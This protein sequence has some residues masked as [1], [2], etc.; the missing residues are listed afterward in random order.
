MIYKLW[1][2]IKIPR[3]SE[4]GF[5]STTNPMQQLSH[6]YILI[7]MYLLL[8]RVLLSISFSQDRFTIIRLQKLTV[9]GFSY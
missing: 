3:S 8:P 9:C 4:M 5:M 2:L 6:P 1:Y 7:L